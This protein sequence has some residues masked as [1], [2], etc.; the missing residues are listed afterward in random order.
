MLI[1]PSQ[2]GRNMKVALAFC[3]KS[4]GSGS[5]EFV[6]R[7]LAPIIKVLGVVVQREGQFFFIQ[8]MSRQIY[9]VPDLCCI[10]SRRSVGVSFRD[11]HPVF[12]C[13]ARQSGRVGLTAQR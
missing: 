6:K 9:A 3:M 1:L 5:K 12:G 11:R 13:R 10:V 8:S 7:G 4:I 2:H